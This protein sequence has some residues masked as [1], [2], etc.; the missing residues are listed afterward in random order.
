MEGGDWENHSWRP[1]WAK[2]YKAPIKKTGMVV[3]TYH[4]STWERRE[5]RKLRRYDMRLVS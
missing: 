5:A 1:P 2:T 3:H 4:S